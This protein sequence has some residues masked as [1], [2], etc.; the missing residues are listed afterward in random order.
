MGCLMV[1][2]GG[3]GSNFFVEKAVQSVEG[4]SEGL[5][6]GFPWLYSDRCGSPVE[7]SIAIPPIERPGRQGELPVI[8]E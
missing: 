6:N 7:S 3:L 8:F 1:P 5:M 4:S 2:A